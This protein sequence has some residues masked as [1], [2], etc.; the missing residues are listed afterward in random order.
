MTNR[1]PGGVLDS[2]RLDA[3]DSDGADHGAGGASADDRRRRH[4]RR[5]QKAQCT[6]P[7]C[8][9]MRRSRKICEIQGQTEGRDR[10]HGGTRP[11]P[12]PDEPAVNP[13]L[14]PYGESFLLVRPLR[15]GEKP[16]EFNAAFRKFL[17]GAE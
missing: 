11:L 3:R 2:A 12:A 10:D 9:S 17:H 13:V 8:I 6:G 4:G 15:P 7:W 1:A 5:T 14:V 16:F